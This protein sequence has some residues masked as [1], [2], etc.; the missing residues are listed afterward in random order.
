V[1]I[2]RFGGALNLSIHFHALV[3]DGVFASEPGSWHFI[4]SAG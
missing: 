1:V 4:R 2:Q 3:P